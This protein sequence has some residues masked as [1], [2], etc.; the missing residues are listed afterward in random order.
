MQQRSVGCLA[1]KS[2]TRE[3]LSKNITVSNEVYKFAND[4][5]NLGC[6]IS[7][8]DQLQP[9]CTLPLMLENSILREIQ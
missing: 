6:D 5:D 7:N 8:I 9:P 1:V 2:C 4:C 3:I